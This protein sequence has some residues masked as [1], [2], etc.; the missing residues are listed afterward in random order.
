MI[1]SFR[2]KVLEAY[3]RTG[4]SK[5]LRPDWIKK[6]NGIL[7]TLH[8]AQSIAEIPPGS[9]RF[10]A[11]SANLKDSCSMRVNRNWRITFKWS[12]IEAVDIFLENHYGD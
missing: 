5:G 12:G 6:I 1:G 11:L 4:K 3:W 7:R 2:Y 8:A 10:E 9:Y